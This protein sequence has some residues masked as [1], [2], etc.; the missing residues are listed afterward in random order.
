MT[1]SAERIAVRG[2]GPFAYS[3]RIVRRSRLG[4][5]PANYGDP[6]TYRSGWPGGRLVESTRSGLARSRRC[7]VRWTPFL[8]FSNAASFSLNRAR[9]PW[10]KIWRNRSVSGRG[11]LAEHRLRVESF[12]HVSA[13]RLPDQV[14]RTRKGRI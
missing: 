13:A 14:P 7:S 11:S 2:Q 8:P 12:P 9:E 3:I 5:L 6:R 1:T 10:R 4:P